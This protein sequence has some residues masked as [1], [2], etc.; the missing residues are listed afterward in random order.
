MRPLVYP[1]DWMFRPDPPPLEHFGRRF[2]AEGDSW[3]TISTL[4][5]FES[6]NVLFKLAFDSSAV[7]INCA[8]PGDTLQRMVDCM[9]DVYFDRLLRQRA[10]AERWDALLISAGG[11]DMIDAAQLPFKDKKGQPT[12]VDHRLLLTPDEAAL[13]IGAA[14]PARYL[15]EAGWTRLADYLLANISELVRRRDQGKNKARP[16]FLHTYALPTV[17]PSGTLG[18]ADGWLHPT[19]VAYDIPD[20]ERQG[21]SDLLFQRLRQLLLDLDQDCG[22]PTALPQV[23]VFDSAGL[24]D[25][26][27][28]QPE[29]TGKSGDWINEIHLSSSGYAKMGQAFGAMIDRVLFSYSRP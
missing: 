3:F 21:L 7:V 8:Y 24:T 4:N 14:G 20:F 22:K 25:I 6:S 19:F 29:D 27:R 18:A 13:A 26:D 16:I 9:G 5:L 23:H 15:S 28:A 2:L 1:S 10:F 12:P 11:N 17:R